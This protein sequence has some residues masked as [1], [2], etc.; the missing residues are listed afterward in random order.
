MKSAADRTPEELMVTAE[1]W[2]VILKEILGVLKPYLDVELEV[3]SEETIFTVHNE[4]K[5]SMTNYVTRTINKR[6]D[7]CSAL[8][9]QCVECP[10]CQ[11]TFTTG[12]DLPDEIWAYLLKRAA[13]L[14]EDQRKLLHTWDSGTLSLERLTEL[15]LRFDRPETLVAQ[16]LATA[17]PKN[18][19]EQNT[20]ASCGDPVGRAPPPEFS[21][22]T[23]FGSDE[24]APSGADW[25]EE[26][27]SADEE[28]ED[29]DDDDDYDLGAFDD[30]GEPLVDPEGEGFNPFDPARGYGRAH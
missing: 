2:N 7:L 29:S 4:S 11:Q 17:P 12:K 25:D 9:Q 8:G 14:T 28:P 6:R 19:F 23:F 22:R 27:D 24:P 13:H 20:A 1:A 5:E 30:D 18:F 26:S 10:N 15:L 21:V 3:L 16:S